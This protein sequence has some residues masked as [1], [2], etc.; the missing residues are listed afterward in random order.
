MTDDKYADLTEAQE[1]ALIGLLSPKE[2]EIYLAD[3]VG[4]SDKEVAAAA[5]TTVG[6]VSKTRSKIR[7]EYIPQAGEIVR[8]VEGD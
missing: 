1:A 2:Q 3:S 4:M 5:D 6:T 8:L 7:S